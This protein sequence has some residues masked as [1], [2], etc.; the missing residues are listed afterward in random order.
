MS[1]LRR[2]IETWMDG[3]N[4][5]G[6][7][8]A[9]ADVYELITVYNDIVHKEKPTFING[10]VKEILDKCNIK[11]IEHGIGWQVTAG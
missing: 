4:V 2:W 11:T 3:K 1:K 5:R 7:S 9:P 10:K 8:V 6:I